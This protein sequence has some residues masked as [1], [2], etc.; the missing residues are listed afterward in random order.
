KMWVFSPDFSQVSK[1]ADEWVAINAGQDGAWWM[2]VNHVL[3][4]EC[5]HERPVPYFIEY[6]K[7]YTDAPYLVELVP[8]PS[9]PEASA[10]D[11]ATPLAHAS[12]SVVFQPGQLLRAGRLA[13]YADVEN[14]DWKFLMWDANAQRPKMPMGSVGFRW[15]KEPGKWNTLLKDGLDGSDIDPA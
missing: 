15:G 3:L 4:K 13:P 8:C 14:K 7:R 1:Y 12:G 10:R 11:A 2:A 6:T 9:E 5:H